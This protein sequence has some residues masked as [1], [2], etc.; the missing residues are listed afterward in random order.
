MFN[1][2]G[3]CN[4][5]VTA[6]VSSAWKKIQEYLSILTEYLSIL[7]GQKISVKTERHINLMYEELFDI[8]QRDLAG[9]SGT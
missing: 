8:R 1:A 6:G 5:A 9:E 7:T 2:D 3:R 4:L